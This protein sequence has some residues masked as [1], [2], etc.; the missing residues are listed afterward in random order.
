M[1]NVVM[2][3]TE[4]GTFGLLREA[5]IHPITYRLHKCSIRYLGKYQSEVDGFGDDKAIGVL[6]KDIPHVS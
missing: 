6:L 4:D 2:I 3:S 1:Y 5:H